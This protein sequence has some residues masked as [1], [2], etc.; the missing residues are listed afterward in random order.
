M[1]IKGERNFQGL[2][3]RRKNKIEDPPAAS[4]GECARY[5]GSIEFRW[6]ELIWLPWLG[7]STVI[8]SSCR[9]D[10]SI[11]AFSEIQKC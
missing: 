2:G 4:C 3:I 9:Y 7:E 1:D 8:L 11:T 5:R 10:L 6:S